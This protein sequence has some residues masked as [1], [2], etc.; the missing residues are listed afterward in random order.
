MPSG[1]AP[2]LSP[3]IAVLDGPLVGGMSVGPEGLPRALGDRPD[4][5]AGFQLRAVY[6][7]PADA[8]DARLDEL[9]AIAR[10][11]RAMGAW[12]SAQIGGRQLRLDSFQGRPDVAFLRLKETGAQALRGE[13]HLPIAA[14]LAAAGLLHPHKSILAYYDG[15]TDGRSPVIGTSTPGVSVIH[16]RQGPFRALPGAGGASGVEFVG[17]H[18]ALHAL[19]FVGPCAPHHQ[20]G[21]HVT[22]DPNDLMSAAL[23]RG[24]VVLDAQ[25]DDYLGH[26]REGCQDLGRSLFLTPLPENPEA[27]VG[28]P[29]ALD[30]GP[31]AA[32]I[33][34]GLPQGVPGDAD[35]EAKLVEALNAARKAAGLEAFV[36]DE[37]FSLAARQA[38]AEG[39][40][41]EMIERAYGFAAATGQGL[42]E[43]GITLLAGL[44]EDLTRLAQGAAEAYGPSDLAS[45][46]VINRLG[47]GAVRRADGLALALLFGRPGPVMAGAR[48]GPSPL[49]TRTVELAL[50]GMQPG[51][52]AYA[53]LDGALQDVPTLVAP[54]GQ[55]TVVASVAAGQSARL[56]VVQAAVSEAEGGGGAQ[57]ERRRRRAVNQLQLVGEVELRGFGPL[58]EAVRPVAPE[59]VGG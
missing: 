30:A 53:A 56:R 3:R 52:M 17:M 50:K 36:V 39:G 31:E 48:V 54:D 23:P 47:V 46:L 25:R 27:P 22:D 8:P 51:A 34:F 45:A 14:N 37:A 19:G 18:E 6:V 32:A 13:I 42:P 49:N 2:D 16:L 11:L 1:L 24:P 55:A 7:V 35:V 26:G 29:L 10:S 15:P 21:D 12:S 44:N 9:G 43:S 4:D 41:A 59:L 40:E 57:S 33:A 5:E 58:P 28:R 38:V 20:E